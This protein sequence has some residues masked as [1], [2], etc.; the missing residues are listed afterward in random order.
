ML[1]HFSLD[2][3]AVTGEVMQKV[4]IE[5]GFRCCTE[6]SESVDTEPQPEVPMW[7]MTHRIKSWHWGL[8]N[9]TLE[10]ICR[11]WFKMVSCHKKHKE[12]VCGTRVITRCRKPSRA[13][14]QETQVT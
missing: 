5:E 10:V 14:S 4:A 2:C 7:S 12:P 6:S 8:E 1:A 13:G 9:L 11:P 3:H